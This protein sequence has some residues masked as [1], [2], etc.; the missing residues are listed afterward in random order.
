MSGI[1][2]VASGWLRVGGVVVG[3]MSF[4]G[5]EAMS[6]A[7]RKRWGSP[8]GRWRRELVADFEDI[9]CYGVMQNSSL[10]RSFGFRTL[11]CSG[12]T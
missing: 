1:E 7:A 12:L 9:S 3:A 8:T 6:F 2:T 5:G 10:T 11:K 4:P